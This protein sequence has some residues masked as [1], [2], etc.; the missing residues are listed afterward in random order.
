MSPISQMELPSNSITPI[1]TPDKLNSITPNLTNSPVAPN[2]PLTGSNK[3]TNIET[4][5]PCNCRSAILGINS[6][7]NDILKVEAQLSALKSFVNCQ[8]SKLRNQTESFTEHKKMLFG[9][10][11]RNID[12]LHKNVV[13]LQNELTEKKQIIKSLMETQ[14]AVLNVMTDL[15]EQPNTPEQNV[16]EH[17]PEEKFNQRSHNYRSKDHSR[18]KQ[19]K[20]N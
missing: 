18:E 14:T 12:A 17:L 20:M 16:T 3:N 1:I 10:E 5:P 8:F 2:K 15:T 9:H 6:N 7:K 11:D 13:F 19:C 4:L